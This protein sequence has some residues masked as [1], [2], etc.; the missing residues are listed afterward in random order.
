MLKNS[1]ILVFGAN[2]LVGSN[3]YKKLLDDKYINTIG[4]TSKDADLR[5]EKEAESIFKLHKPEY[6]FLCAAKVGG[7][8]ANN[9]YPVEF[10]YDNIMIEMNIIKLCYKYSVSK[11]LFLGSNCIY[12][13]EC[14][15]PI[16][17]D[18]LLTGP[19]EPTNKPYAIAKIAGI[20]LCDAYNREY[21]TNFI[22]VMPINIYGPGDK[23]NNE[24][25][26]MLPS[27]I[28]KIHTAKINNEPNVHL[29]GDGTPLRE[30]MYAEDLA[31]ALILI[32]NSYND[33]ELINI[34]GGEEYTIKEIANIIKDVIEYKGNIL[35]DINNLNGTPRKVLDNSK[36]KKLNWH[37]KTKLKDGIINIYK[38]YLKLYK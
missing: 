29:W 21:N 8:K 4:I 3:L 32:M 12:P 16:T 23:Y 20:E 15:Q 11:L 22:S 13:K 25:S 2:G 19:L 24:N 34:G 35:F 5:I 7:I 30:C 10:L 9:T 31:E 18:M 6:V 38:E 1:K 33:K 28:H 37:P 36:L 14:E 27:L 26:H 17:E